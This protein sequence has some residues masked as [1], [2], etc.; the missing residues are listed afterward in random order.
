MRRLGLCAV[1]TVAACAGAAPSP[2]AGSIAARPAQRTEQVVKVTAQKFEFTPSVIRLKAGA[3]AV[4]ELTTLDRR[5]GFSVPD[6]G[7]DEEIAPGA[8]T[9]VRLAPDKSGEYPFHC[10]V[11]CGDGHETM[12]GR[13]VVEP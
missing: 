1:L 5:H 7:I 12:T 13:I 3:P 6:L 8:P 9:V 10:S 11:F 2:Y 4:I